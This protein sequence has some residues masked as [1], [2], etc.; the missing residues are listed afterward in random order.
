MT[1]R[2]KNHS[3]KKEKY[4]DYGSPQIG[5]NVFQALGYQAADHWKSRRKNY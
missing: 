1:E 2:K 4:F 5:L 3:K